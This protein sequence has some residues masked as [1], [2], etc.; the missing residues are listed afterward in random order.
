MSKPLQKVDGTGMQRGKHKC[1]HGTKASGRQKGYTNV[2]H[3]AA[4]DN[5]GKQRSRKGSNDTGSALDKF[6]LGNKMHLL[7]FKDQTQSMT[8]SHQDRPARHLTNAENALNIGPKM[9]HWHSW[10]S[11]SQQPAASSNRTQTSCGIAS[12]WRWSTHHNIFQNRQAHRIVNATYQ[13]FQDIHI[14]ATS[15]TK[16]HMPA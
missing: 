3:C 14:T 16:P 4:T 8:A 1:K 10:K 11:A 12:K 9:R 13:I 2:Q 15:M 6:D 5:T 7:P